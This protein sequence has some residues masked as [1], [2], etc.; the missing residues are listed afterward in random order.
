[1]YSWL[2]DNTQGNSSYGVF[3]PWSRRI[4]RRPL[5]NSRASFPGWRDA[6]YGNGHPFVSVVPEPMLIQLARFVE[7]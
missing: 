5:E 1:M 2:Q 7:A 3:S 4:V 6:G